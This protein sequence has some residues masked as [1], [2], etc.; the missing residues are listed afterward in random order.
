MME[1]YLRYRNEELYIE[2]QCIH[3]FLGPDQEGKNN[4]Y[5][6]FL[7]LAENKSLSLEEEA[8]FGESF[9]IFCI[10]EKEI[11]S[12]Q[13]LFLFLERKEDFLTQLESQKKGT[14][15][16]HYIKNYIESFVVQR[17]IEE[18]RNTLLEIENIW[19]DD[20]LS[21]DLQL[22]IHW[23]LN[24]EIMKHVD[25]CT[26]QNYPLYSLDSQSLVLLLLQMLETYLRQNSEYVVVILK[27]LT[28]FL[29]QEAMKECI[30]GLQRLAKKY[31]QLILFY[32]QEK[33]KIYPNDLEEILYIGVDHIQLPSFEIMKETIL[34]HYPLEYTKEDSVLYAEMINTLLAISV[35]EETENMLFYNTV[36]E[37]LL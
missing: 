24:Q 31:P 35:D 34:F 2:K 19:M 33:E 37:L 27:N 6:L 17:Y 29:S 1:L 4:F 26:H 16:F 14:L 11:K 30:E 36:K 13:A 23:D 21:K 28:Q 20:E 25:L 32:F 8:Y 7:R 3:Y 18:C 9:P 12:K 10:D 22:Q 15:S 5:Q